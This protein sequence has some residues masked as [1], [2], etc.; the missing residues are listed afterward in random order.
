MT[1]DFDREQIEAAYAALTDVFGEGYPQAATLTQK[2]DGFVGHFVRIDE[3]VD[4]KTGFAPVDMLVF[5]AIAGVWH[6]E[7]GAI[8][9][10]RKGEVYSFALMHTTVRNRIE[11]AKP[12]VSD[13][14]VAVRRGRVFQSTF[15]EGNTAV[16]YDVTF[17]G[18]PKL[19]P[20]DEL[21]ADEP[22][23]KAKRARKSTAA[24]SADVDPNE[25]PF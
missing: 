16:A 22:P 25:E 13:E 1:T 6:V 11:E 5:R 10:A 17:P 19:D 24:S 7:G 20:A 12:V 8:E 23:A 9:H 15:N 2:G 3:G 4:L 21:P 18:R 14:V